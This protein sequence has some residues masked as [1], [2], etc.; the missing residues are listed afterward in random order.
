MGTGQQQEATLSKVDLDFSSHESG[1]H[2]TGDTLESAASRRKGQPGFLHHCGHMTGER[3]TECRGAFGAHILS[4]LEDVLTGTCSLHL[5]PNTM[6]LSMSALRSTTQMTYGA[7]IGAMDHPL[8]HS[9]TA[10]GASGLDSILAL[11]VPNVHR[12]GLCFH[13]LSLYS[14]GSQHHNGSWGGLTITIPCSPCLMDLNTHF[15]YE[16]FSP[17]ADT[18]KKRVSK[19]TFFVLVRVVDEL[20]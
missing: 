12:P 10:S 5:R 4:G 7:S 8:Q 9:E 20:W 15:T 6:T 1:Y 13:K 16:K 2:E 11:Y 14:Q 19:N 17:F 3:I 18:F